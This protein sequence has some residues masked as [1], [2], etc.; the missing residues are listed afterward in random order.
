MEH[1]IQLRELNLSHN[2]ITKIEN[3]RLPT[4]RELN[5]SDNFIKSTQGLEFLP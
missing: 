5:L 3:L 1:C 2:N 4:L